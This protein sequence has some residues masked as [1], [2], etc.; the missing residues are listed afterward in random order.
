MVVVP[1]LCLCMVFYKQ[2]LVTKKKKPAIIHPK[3]HSISNNSQ[4]IGMEESLYDNIDET[5]I[6]GLI[7]RIE[8]PPHNILI[9]GSNNTVNGEDTPCFNEGQYATKQ[10]HPVIKISPPTIKDYIAEA[11]VHRIDSGLSDNDG[12][13]LRENGNA[14]VK[15]IICL[16]YPYDI[17]SVSVRSTVP[18]RCFSNETGRLSKSCDNLNIEDFKLGIFS[19]T[20]C[21]RNLTEDIKLDSVEICKAKS[22]SF[23]V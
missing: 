13:T 21:K 7:E 5:H 12:R 2:K 18:K 10:D 19:E 1:G 3:I 23:I 8:I 17:P 16:S 9:G 6:L 22:E 15:D 11:I 4:I 14:L 20:N